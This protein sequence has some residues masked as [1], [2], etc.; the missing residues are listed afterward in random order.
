MSPF[1]SVI[2][3]THN[4]ERLIPRALDSILSQ[5]CDDWEVVVVDDGSNDATPAVLDRYQKHCSKFIVVQHS[6]NRGVSAARNT[7]IENSNGR[8]ITFLDS[9]DEYAPNHLA[10]RKKILHQNPEIQLLHGGMEVIG[11]PFVIDKD[12]YGKRIH[13]TDCAVGGTFFIRRDVLK[14]VG[15]FSQLS[16]AEAADFFERSLEAGVIVRKTSSP[17]YRYFRTTKNQITTNFANTTQRRSLHGW[18]RDL[19]LR[20]N[21]SSALLGK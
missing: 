10:N 14:M 8:Y 5:R 18:V 15:Q 3:C 16:Y 12:D 4:R 6:E 19:M 20:I 2:V 7:G 9:D 13:L 1:F 17:S 11:D 21:C